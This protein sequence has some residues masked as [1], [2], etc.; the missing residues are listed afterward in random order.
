V[1]KQV[2]GEELSVFYVEAEELLVKRGW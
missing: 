2:T 1:F